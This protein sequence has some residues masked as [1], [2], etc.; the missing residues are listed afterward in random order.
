MKQN[1]VWRDGFIYMRDDI[2]Y[3]NV[4]KIVKDLTSQYKF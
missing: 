3:T 4:T 1:V 2:L